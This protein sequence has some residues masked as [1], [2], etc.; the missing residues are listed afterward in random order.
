MADMVLG[1]NRVSSQKIQKAGFEF[2]FPEL[3]A[4]LKDIFS[5]KS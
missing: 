3:K 5:G 4:A 2:E 1:G